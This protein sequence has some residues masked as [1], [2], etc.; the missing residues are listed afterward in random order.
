[1]YLLHK[2]LSVQ[3]S[4]VKDAPHCTRDIYDLPFLLNET[5]MPCY[6]Q[7]FL[8]CTQV[9]KTLQITYDAFKPVPPPA[10]TPI[11]D[12]DIS[13]SVHTSVL[14]LMAIYLFSLGSSEE[15]SSH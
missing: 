14:L 13:L 5:I 4:I 2:C 8:T 1:M 10:N 12:Q 7:T 15:R 11:N 3:Y 6:Q 9:A